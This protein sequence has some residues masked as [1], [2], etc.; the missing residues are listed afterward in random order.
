[1]CRLFFVCLAMSPV[2]VSA[3][4]HRFVRIF[5]PMEQDKYSADIANIP[6]D[7]YF[8]SLDKEWKPEDLRIRI[9]IYRPVRENF[10][11]F[12]EQDAKVGGPLANEPA[13]LQFSLDMK[14]KKHPAPGTYLYRVDCFDKTGKEEKLLAS[15]AVFIT[16]VKGERDPGPQASGH[17]SI[18]TQR[19]S[20]LDGHAA[21]SR[22]SSRPISR[23]RASI[24]RRGLFVQSGD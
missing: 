6:G 24:T 14:L 4:E 8:Y 5:M 12:Q 10:E 2:A 11:V 23:R 22:E 20:R 1:M 21:R 3:V 15:N 18:R 17:R 9:R 13:T 16:F 19:V 7:G